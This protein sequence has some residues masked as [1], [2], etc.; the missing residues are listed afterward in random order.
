MRCG[1]CNAKF[2]GDDVWV[3]VGLTTHRHKESVELVLESPFCIDCVKVFLGQG[4]KL[5]TLKEANAS[6]NADK[7]DLLKDNKALRWELSHLK[8]EQS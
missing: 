7:R 2:G 5:Q 8:G 4:S 3:S 6:L 1:E